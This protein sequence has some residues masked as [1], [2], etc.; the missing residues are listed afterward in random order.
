MF[1]IA[2]AHNKMYNVYIKVSYSKC[3]NTL[4]TFTVGRN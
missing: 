3:S 4:A 1:F 2:I